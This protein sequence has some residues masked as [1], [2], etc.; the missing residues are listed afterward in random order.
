VRA[1]IPPQKGRQRAKVKELHRFGVGTLLCLA[2]TAGFAVPA[3]AAGFL[4]TGG[5]ATNAVP[6]GSSGHSVLGQAGIG[7]AGGS[8]WV[9]AT[10]R[11]EG[12]IALTVFDVGSESAWKDQ[13]RIF[14]ATTNA[15]VTDG[16]NHDAGTTG[17]FVNGSAPFQFVASITQSSGVTNMRFFR[18]LPDPDV[19]L[20]INGQ[21]PSS[22][23]G[24]G[25]A[26]LAFAYLDDTYQVVSGPTNR[27]LV[28]LEDGSGDDRDYDDYVGILEGPPV[29]PP[30]PP[31]PVVL[32]ISGGTQVG[33]IPQG[34]SG[35]PVLPQAGIGIADGQIWL[36]GTLDI[37]G[38]G[39]TL[40]L[41]DVGSESHWINEIR[42]GNSAGSVL[43]DL[44]DHYRGTTESFTNGP[45]PF[46]LAGTVTQ[47]SGVA[48]FEFRRIDPTPEYQIVVNG[49]SPMM[50]VPEYGFASI[51]LAYLSDANQIVSF[52]TN[53]VLVLLE[54]GGTD[55]DYDDYVG[56]LEANVTPPA[57]PV[58]PNSL[59]FGDVPR[60]TSSS[61]MTVTITNNGSKS[62]AIG[63][64]KVSGA[65]PKQFTRS[66]QCPANLPSGSS[67]TVS[68]VFKP[69]FATTA[70]A[71]LDLKV[72]GSLKVVGLFG[73]GI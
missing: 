14:N 64:P 50:M 49:Q 36:D 19:R 16:D 63:Q 40:T 31:P 37:L 38:N 73:R 59:A 56:I 67:C 33:T 24:S 4:I 18:V 60:N 6:E 71:T 62:L 30:P 45:A 27:I 34:N 8:I 35:N 25:S 65:N 2:V 61:P 28:L 23:T 22:V 43:S 70:Y 39:A 57:Y 52:P 32:S 58:S 69:A 68:V 41:Y 29:E 54:D 7:F 66:N 13:F 55:R 42:L 9:D 48:D 3:E 10:L 20:V 53:R 17:V 11:N 72:G 46:Q 26:S 12:D 5:T 44:D 47:G 1:G 15:N 51:A 21:S